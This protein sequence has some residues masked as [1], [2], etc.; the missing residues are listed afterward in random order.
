MADD[1]ARAR[2]LRTSRFPWAAVIGVALGVA[3]VLVV[4][5]FMPRAK[6]DGTGASARDGGAH[7]PKPLA[8]ALLDEVEGSLD[9]V[10][11]HYVP[12]LEPLVAPTYGDFL[13]TLDPS[14]RLVAVV[15]ND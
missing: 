15:P 3:I 11:F 14:T 2:A 9:E 8:G 4:L 13:G 5:R 10:L 1:D 6:D 12:R 7:D